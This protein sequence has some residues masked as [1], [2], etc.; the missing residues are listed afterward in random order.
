MDLAPKTA[1]KVVGDDVVETLIE[2][3]QVGDILL[4]KP[5]MSVP[6][7]GVIIEGSSSIDQAAI[8]GESV[9]V[10]KRLEIK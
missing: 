10:E 3:I 4:V 8:T 7:D 2:E 9:P 5:G 6:L 1:L